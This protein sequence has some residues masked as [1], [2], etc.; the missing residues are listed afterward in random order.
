MRVKLGN[1]NE[2]C[3][4]NSVV[5]IVNAYFSGNLEGLLSIET[6]EEKI[7]IPTRTIKEQEVINAEDFATWIIRSLRTEP[8]LY[9]SGNFRVYAQIKSFHNESSPFIEA[10]ISGVTIPTYQGTLVNL[11]RLKEINQNEIDPL[12]IGNVVTHELGHN[13]GLKDYHQQFGHDSHCLM[14]QSSGNIKRL[15]KEITNRK[16]FCEE[17]RDAILGKQISMKQK[18]VRRLK[19]NLFLLP[20]PKNFYFDI[21]EKNLHNADCNHKLEET[22]ALTFRY[23]PQGQGYNLCDSLEEEYGK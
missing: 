12:I 9:L 21:K 2:E 8:T 4:L 20:K 18:I 10:E 13:L 22:I 23:D 6:T 1:L 3:N 14:I 5:K 11:P 7:E 15:Y 17:C 19:K 16:G